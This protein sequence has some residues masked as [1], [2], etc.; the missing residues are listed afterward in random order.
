MHPDTATSLNNLA[1]T[2]LRRGES[3]KALN[4]QLRALEIRQ[5][6]LGDRHVGN[7]LKT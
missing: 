4:L 6:V 2:Y 5:K 3:E 7:H 1:L